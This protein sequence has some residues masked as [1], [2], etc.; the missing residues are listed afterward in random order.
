[1]LTQGEVNALFDSP[2][3]GYSKRT[4]VDALVDGTVDSQGN[5]SLSLTENQAEVKYK[6]V[7]R[8][9]QS[10]LVVTDQTKGLDF[11]VTLTGGAF[12]TIKCGAETCTGI[13]TEALTLTI[14]PES[15]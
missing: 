15:L 1:M 11:Q 3:H 4:Y 2:E 8:T 9:L 6:F 7:G 5:L 14:N 12:L 10:A 13:N